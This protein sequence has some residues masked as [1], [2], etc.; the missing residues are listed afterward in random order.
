MIHFT[1]ITT[2]NFG[3]E[4]GDQHTYTHIKDDEKI[5]FSNIERTVFVPTLRCGP[6]MYLSLFGTEVPTQ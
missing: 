4:R 1:S 3:L 6:A 5:Y 2:D